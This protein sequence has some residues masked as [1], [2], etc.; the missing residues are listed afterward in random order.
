MRTLSLSFS[1]SL[2]SRPNDKME[3]RVTYTNKGRRV[4][5]AKVMA[6]TV[7]DAEQRCSVVVTA[8]LGTVMG[9]REREREREKEGKE[10]C[11]RACAHTY[12]YVNSQ[13]WNCKVQYL[14]YYLLL[15]SPG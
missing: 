11:V 5:K 10:R 15:H 12:I 8:A 14:A 2:P 6:C 4:V 1:L 7:G 9:E 3:E 13:F